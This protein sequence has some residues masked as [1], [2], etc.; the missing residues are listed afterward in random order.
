MAA[1]RLS[2]IDSA[3]IFRDQVM[4]ILN[5]FF[6]SGGYPYYVEYVHKEP[7]KKHSSRKISDI[8]T[9]INRLTDLNPDDAIGLD[10]WLVNMH[11][12][13]RVLLSVR[14]SKDGDCYVK[15]VS[16]KLK[17]PKVY[18][19]SLIKKRAHFLIV[20]KDRF[21]NATDLFSNLI[22]IEAHKDKW[23]LRDSKGNENRIVFFKIKSAS[24]IYCKPDQKMLF[25]EDPNLIQQIQKILP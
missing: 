6:R 11:S 9:D 22:P 14:S 17:L 24:L 4:Q 19:D 15:N 21:G 1:K 10:F 13:E 5:D 2:D 7:G 3:K 23:I 8:N 25:S 12:A 20:K 16:D 18:I